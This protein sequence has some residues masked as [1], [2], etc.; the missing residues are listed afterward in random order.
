[1]ATF[2]RTPTLTDV[3][4]TGIESALWDMCKVMPGRVESYD[5]ARQMVNVQPLLKKRVVLEDGSETT[6]S[7]PVVPNVPLM[8]FGGGGYRVTL[9]IQKG[10]TVL[11]VFADAS[12]D[13][14]KARGGEV[15]PI[16]THSHHVADAIAIPGLHADNARWT[17]ADQSELT[18]GKDGGLQVHVSGSEINL[19][20]GA[21]EHAILGDT[22]QSSLNTFFTALNTY[23]TSVATAVP[24]T[25][26]A[27]TILE[28]AITVVKAA[29]YKSTTVKVKG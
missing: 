7:R 9:P 25:A 18:I 24:A 28:T 17:G 19:G 12:M 20:G 11:V 16:A 1:M 13:I 23:L 4:R 29:V 27:A 21:T 10:D 5:A 3:I 6:E 22:L 14:W 26:P 8:L 2:T 15:D